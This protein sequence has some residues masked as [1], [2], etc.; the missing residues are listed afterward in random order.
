MN[1]I[2]FIVNE[3]I[4]NSTKYLNIPVILVPEKRKGSLLQFS[5]C[6]SMDKIPREYVTEGTKNLTM[7]IELPEQ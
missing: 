4:I 2:E 1:K 7:I 3:L 5:Y 6:T